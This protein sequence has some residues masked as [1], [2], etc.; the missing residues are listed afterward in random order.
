MTGTRRSFDLGFVGSVI[1]LVF[2]AGLAAFLFAVTN[3]AGDAIPRPLV[4]A[5]LYATPG[6]VGL[7]GALA[8]R[9][10]LL[11]GAAIPLFPGALLS[12]AG[13]TLAFVLP[14][15]LLIAG[16]AAIPYR[17]RSLGARLL[18]VGQGALISL[19]IL[20]AAWA[21]LFGLARSGCF[22]TAGGTTCG[23]GFI[24]VEGVG[25]GLT[26]LVVAIAI[27]A[28]SAFISARASRAAVD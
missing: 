25:V 3:S 20:I 19:L 10:S 13:V 24:S 15:V 27:A 6:V 23:T 22:P 12:W 8:R 4:L 7:L 26:S 18:D 17:T 21:S 1:C 2:A 16:A 28:W 5:G 11:V 14:G 9:R